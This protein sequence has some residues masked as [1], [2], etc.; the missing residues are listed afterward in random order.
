MPYQEPT[1]F[2]CT[3]GKDRAGFGS[4]IGL[5]S[6][7]TRAAIGTTFGLTSGTQTYRDLTVSR[8]DIVKE[9]KAQRERL[10]SA[11][12]EGIIGQYE[13]TQ[14]MFDVNQTIAMH[15]LTAVSYTH[16]RAK[17]TPEHIV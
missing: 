5:T 1:L 4:A 11:Y 7:M 10:E 8:T 15:D 6:G 2:H 3:A 16:L 12:R 14:M 9:A 17:E 13:Y